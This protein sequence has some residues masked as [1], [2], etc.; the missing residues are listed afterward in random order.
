MKAKA[1]L[2]VAVFALSS[3]ALLAPAACYDAEI[4]SMSIEG[5]NVVTIDRDKGGSITLLYTADRNTTCTI[6]IYDAALSTP[7]SSRE[8]KLNA[9]SDIIVMDLDY[10][11]KGQDQVQMKLT[12]TN[13]GTTLYKDIGF[14]LKYSTS[15]WSNWAVYGIIIAIVILIIALVVFKSR[16]APKKEKNALTFEQIEA[17]KQAQKEAPKQNKT[18]VKSERQRYLASKK[19]K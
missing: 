13:G 12:F 15:I 5:G 6:S 18:E 16:I 11:K 19:Q 10:N 4:T 9:D 1:I 2:V 14:T 17:E 3:L 8:V 7:V